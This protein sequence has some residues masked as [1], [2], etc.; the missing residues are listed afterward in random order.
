MAKLN[1]RGFVK[2]S[3]AAVA[4]GT[5][6]G[7]RELAVGAD[8]QAGLDV[9]RH[10]YKSLKWGMIRTDG[11]TLEKF[12]MLKELGYDGVELDSPEG[13][14]KQE[15][16]RASRETGLP[17]EGIVNST[18]WRIRH[19]DPDPAVRARALE[20]MRTALRDAKYVG[21][22]SVLLVPGKVTDP[23]TEN[24][25]QVWER[26]IAEIR[27]LLPLSEELQVKILIENV[28]NGFCYDPKQFA[29]YIDEINSPWVGVHFD[30][31]NHIWVSPP[32][33]WIRILGKRIRKLD[34][35]DRT[36]TREKTK[37]GEGD[38]D[39][40]SVRK[41][42]RE[43]GYRGW[44]AAEVTG[45]DRDRLAEILQ[46]MNRVVGESDGRPPRQLPGA[47]KGA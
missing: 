7:F 29:Q 39:W 42:L 46:R 10:V 31:G 23:E 2:A 35:K 37:I 19:S 45:G 12:T 28:G 3:S 22:D 15:A 16:L 33:E 25:D 13:V 36:K 47:T 27:K 41:A 4:I 8:D 14:D 40:P 30:V 20:N 6:G 44:A 5:V 11:S 1:R 26:S 9:G 18:H 21:A 43:I 38:A 32:A 17:I 24:H 34:I